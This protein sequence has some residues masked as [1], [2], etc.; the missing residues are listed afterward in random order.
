MQAARDTSNVVMVPAA[1][2]SD[3][4]KA[5]LG[6]LGLLMMGIV[7]SIL[8][9]L[10]LFGGFFIGFALVAVVAALTFLVLPVVAVVG[11]TQRLRAQRTRL[12]T[13]EWATSTPARDAT[14]LPSPEV[15]AIQEKTQVLTGAPTT[16]EWSEVLARW[17]LSDLFPEAVILSSAEPSAKKTEGAPEP[18]KAPHDA[19]VG[20]IYEEPMAEA[21]PRALIAAG[22]AETDIQIF[23]KWPE[24]MESPPSTYQME[25]LMQKL[26]CP[27]FA[28]YER[29]LNQNK[30]RF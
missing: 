22:F 12:D 5:T 14:A 30:K 7:S 2:T 9:L 20:V 1:R 26:K 24:G 3:P 13:R 27:G 15:V 19:V 23:P 21:A 16:A 17:S 25:S 10:G 6:Y 11:L 4:L 18:L 29:K 8:L 28:I